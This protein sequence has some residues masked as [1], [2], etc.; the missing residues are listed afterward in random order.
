[1]YFPLQSTSTA[2]AGIFKP[3]P[4]AT[5]FPSLTTI[6]AFVMVVPASFTMVALVKAK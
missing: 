5:I 6:V 4:T 3:L 1:M 2:P